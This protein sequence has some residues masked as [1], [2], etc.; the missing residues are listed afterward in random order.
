MTNRTV[1]LC[2]ALL[3]GFSSLVCGD[4]PQAPKTPP[5][6]PAPKAPITSPTN[7]VAKPPTASQDPVVADF[8]ARI[9]AYE[10]L[11]KKADDGVTPLK[12]TEAPEAIKAA[13]KTLAARIQAAR[14]N[15]KH[16]DIFTPQ[17][18]KLLRRLMRPEA[19][20]G[21]KASIADDN[22]GADLPFKVN[23][24][25]P[26]KETVSTV[27]PEILAS[28]PQ[29]PEGLEYRFG[30]KHLILRDARANLIVDYIPNA[31]P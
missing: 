5:V 19:D 28:L 4:G 10:D 24:P 17:V 13:E 26:E 18:S 2:A 9:K 1:P 11:R 22:P 12:Q 8:M 7:P 30:G 14:A 23:A 31:L 29:L 15:A 20:K 6:A 25:Y 16:G 3:L 27:P 21:T